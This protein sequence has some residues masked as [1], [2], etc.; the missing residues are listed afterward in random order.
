VHQSAYDDAMFT[1][2]GGKGS[3]TGGGHGHRP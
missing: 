3:T 1:M 2:K